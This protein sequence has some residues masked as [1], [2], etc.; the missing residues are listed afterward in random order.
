[1]TLVQRPGSSPL[2]ARYAVLV[3]F[4]VNGMGMGIW[5]SRLPAVKHGL[6][7]EDGQVAIVIF[8]GAVGAMLSLRAAGPLIERFGSRRTTQIAAVFMMLSLLIPAAAR[9]LPQLMVGML[10]IAAGSSFQDVGMNSQA[11]AIEHRLA[12]PIMSSFH[13]AFS[14]GAILGAAG[15]AIT[16]KLNV[17]YQHTFAGFAVVLVAAVLVANRWLLNAPETSRRDASE[18]QGRGGLPHRGVL[19]ALGVIGLASFIA[20]GSAADWA[21]IYLRDDTGTTAAVAAI[22]FMIFNITMTAG[23]LAGDRLAARFGAMFLVRAGTAVA[24]IGLLG[25]LLG[26][27]TAAGIAGFAVM[28]IGLSIIVPQ[29]FSA[30]AQLAPGRAPAA[31]SLVSAISYFG[32]LTGP[33]AIGAVAH[34]ANLR[35]AL[36]IPAA[37]I[38][39]SSL[40]ASRLHTASDS[41]LPAAADELRAR[42]AQP[43]AGPLY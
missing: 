26:R 35:I 20:E 43:G 24:G 32:F 25:G 6:R 9:N 21:A 30:A 18:M 10:L 41:P 3:H 13:A 1:M 4:L 7:L 40:V 28:G 14:V 33:A 17:S 42:A 37:L 29:V 27:T 2:Q 11:V 31:L 8:A 15:G 36:V 34:A 16:A 39:A 23:R 19:I 5:A 38:L 22:G 12:K